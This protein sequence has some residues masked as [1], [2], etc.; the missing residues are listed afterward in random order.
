MAKRMQLCVKK[1]FKVVG[2]MV[3]RR[4]IKETATTEL[5]SQVSHWNARPVFPGLLHF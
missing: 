1:Y 2:V 3:I 4:G 5:P